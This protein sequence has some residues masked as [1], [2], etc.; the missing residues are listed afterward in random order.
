MLLV[1]R[2]GAPS[3]FLFLVVMH[4]LLVAM[5][6]ATAK[7][8]TGSSLF[9]LFLK[10]S[11]GEDSLSSC[12]RKKRMTKR[13]TV[14]LNHASI[15]RLVCFLSGLTPNFNGAAMHSTHKLP[16]GFPS[17]LRF[18]RMSHWLSVG[19]ASFRIHLTVCS[20]TS[21]HNK[22]NISWPFNRHF[23]RCLRLDA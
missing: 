11:H 15:L 9:R 17:A 23:G 19:Q 20:Q 13:I 22:K 18:F 2:P 1:V 16:F 8:H 4:L 12:L 10:E 14:A 7:K 3:S 6:S 5:H 21:K